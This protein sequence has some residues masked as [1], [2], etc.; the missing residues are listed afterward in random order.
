MRAV[1][2]T[3]FN[4]WAKAG[5]AGAFRGPL[6]WGRGGGGRAPS[7]ARGRRPEGAGGGAGAGAARGR[8]SRAVCR[9]AVVVW[10]SVQMWVTRVVR[11]ARRSCNV[12][13]SW[14]TVG[15]AGLWVT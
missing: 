12:W 4:C 6:A 13:S 8:R 7:A 15:G 11:V 10:R 2:R 3:A 5:L 14:A 1:L 9:A